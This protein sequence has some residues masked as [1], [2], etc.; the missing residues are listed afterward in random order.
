MDDEYLLIR[1]VI[2]QL[3]Q[4]IDDAQKDNRPE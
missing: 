3:I 2:D 1:D 4:E